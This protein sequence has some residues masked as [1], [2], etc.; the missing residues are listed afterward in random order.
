MLPSPQKQT[1][2]LLSVPA[3]VEQVAQSADLGLPKKHYRPSV[4][5]WFEG[6]LSIAGWLLCVLLSYF[7]IALFMRHND[8]LELL[9]EYFFIVLLVAGALLIPALLLSPLV[10]L[11]HEVTSSWGF[12]VYDRGLVYK[13]G[14]RATAWR[15]EQ[16][17]ALWLE[18]REKIRMI[19]VGDSFVDYKET[20]RL[21]KLEFQDGKKIIFDLHLVRM[22]ELL[23]LLDK[24]I[25]N[26]LL[27][28]VIAAFEQGDTVTFGDLRL[29]REEVSW[30][31]KSLFWFE[32]R[33]FTLRDTSLIIEKIDKKRVYWDLVAMPNIGLFQG[34]KD[35][36]FQRY[37]GITELES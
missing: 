14:R 29:N 19:A 32:I 28:Q 25:R 15:W 1:Q 17:T 7:V 3:E 5:T 22:Q 36:I 37:Q 11:A 9:R 10:L 12:Y 31:D 2:S 24:Q 23:D 33:A 8:I 20:R 21:Y 26:H 4:L 16:I 34:L 18:V 27:P 6:L 30:K 35:Y 13:R